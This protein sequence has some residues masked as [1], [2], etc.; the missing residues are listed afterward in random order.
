MGQCVF[1]P[2]F[3]LGGGSG[4]TYDGLSGKRVVNFL[5]VLIELFSLTITAKALR[6]QLSG[7]TGRYDRSCNKNV[8]VHFK[9]SI[10]T[11]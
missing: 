9:F 5:L 3:F 4:T 10:I 7:H 11:V 8:G 2:T 1:E 6:R